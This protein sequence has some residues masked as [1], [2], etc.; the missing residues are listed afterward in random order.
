MLR[1]DKKKMTS[2]SLLLSG[3]ITVTT[4][5]TV[6]IITIAIVVSTV[7]AFAADELMIIGH[8]RPDVDTVASAIAYTNL[9]NMMGVKEAFPAVAGDLN[10][11]TKFVLDY[12]KV[13]YPEKITN[14]QYRCK[15]VIL[16][17]HNDMGQAVDNLNLILASLLTIPATPLSTTNLGGISMSLT[18]KSLRQ[19]Q[20]PIWELTPSI[21]RNHTRRQ[22]WIRQSTGMRLSATTII[23][24]WVQ[25][26]WTIVFEKT[27]GNHT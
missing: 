8:A 21:T 7:P 12:F 9:K 5:I 26:R 11:E 19:A 20:A 4:C 27:F 3:G 22:G 23:S 25:S 10:N 17:D 2:R 13:P 18:A 6:L 24:G 14:C 15:K 16:V 1:K